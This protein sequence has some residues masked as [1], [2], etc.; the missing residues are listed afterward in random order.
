MD[1]QLALLFFSRV[2]CPHT[3][4]HAAAAVTGRSRAA[5][6]E[7]AAANLLGKEGSTGTEPGRAPSVLDP[8]WHSGSW[9]ALK[10]QQS[11]LE[12][13]FQALQE[14]VRLNVL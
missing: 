4:P 13:C 1:L 8:D 12:R 5:S 11:P 14:Q 3:L 9:W 2:K 6:P 7:P 10:Q